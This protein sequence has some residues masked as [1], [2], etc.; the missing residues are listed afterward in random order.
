MR[1]AIFAHV[2]RELLRNITIPGTARV[3]L[4]PPR[5]KMQ[6]V[7]RYRRVERVATMSRFH[8]RAVAPLVVERPRAGWRFRGRFGIQR[9][10]IGL[11]QYAA[12][13]SRHD[14]VLVCLA[15]HDAAHGAFPDARLIVAR[16]EEVAAG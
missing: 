11:V 9:E 6:L 8:P 14:S 13:I 7:D 12:A 3:V 15:A 10:R 5:S 2:I 4:A 1:K 16:D